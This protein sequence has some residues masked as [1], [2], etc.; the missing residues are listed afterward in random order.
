M[1][2]HHIPDVLTTGQFLRV[3]SMMRSLAGVTIPPDRNHMIAGRLQRRLTENQTTDFT[4]YLDLVERDPVER[5][6]FVDLLTTHETFFFREP[7]HFARLHE[8]AAAARGTFRVWSAAC[9]TGEEAYSAAMT[10]ANARSGRSWSVVAT[11][12]ST[13]VLEVAARGIYPL[14]RLQ[15]MP[16][17]YLKSYA[18]QG[19]GPYEGTFQVKPSLRQRVRFT[20][21][22]LSRELPFSEKFDAVFLRNVLIYFDRATQERII[23][24]ICGVLRPDGVLFL[25]SSESARGMDHFLEYDG[26][27]CWRRKAQ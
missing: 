5:S 25:G 11:D 24:R 17:G 19:A 15:H 4:D 21:A 10:A 23:R 14:R 22:N 1:M 12:I 7:L 27:T 8:L 2:M 18:L 9:S 26:G 3:Q 20:E 6:A 16:E 13:R